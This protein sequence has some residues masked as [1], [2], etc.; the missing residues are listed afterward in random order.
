[1]QNKTDINTEKEGRQKKK[2]KSNTKVLKT[3][4]RVEQQKISM[5]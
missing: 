3:F 5:F 1:M 2:I 4:P